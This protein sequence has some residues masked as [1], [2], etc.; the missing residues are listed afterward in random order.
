MSRDAEIAPLSDAGAGIRTERGARRPRFRGG[1]PASGLLPAAALVLCASAAGIAA[2]STPPDVSGLIP[3]IGATV[4]AVR[5]V[6]V[7]F[8][9]EVDGVDAGDLLLDGVPAGRVSGE[10]KGPYIFGFE[11]ASGRIAHVS[12]APDHGIR[13]RATPPNAFEGGGWAYRVD[14]ALPASRVL[15]GEILADNPG[16]LEDAD[17]D[18][19]DWIEVQN[20]GDD[21][22]NLDGWGLTDE[23]T[24]LD[25]WVFPP[26][27]LAPRER[28]VVFASGKDRSAVAE[29]LH[30]SFKLELDGEF[31]ALTS[32]PDAAAGTSREAVSGFW[33]YPPQRIGV[34][35]GLDASGESRYFIVPTPG[36]VNV[37]GY[38]GFV[39]DTKFGEDRGF[40]DGPFEVAITTETAGARITYTVDGSEPTEAEGIPYTGPVAISRTTTLR[41]AA[42]RAGLIPTNVDTHTYIFLDDVVSQD[43]AGFPASW[44]SVAADYRVDPEVTGSPLYGA[45]FRDDL[46]SAPTLS[47][48]MRLED[49]FG[50]TG[51]YTNPERTGTAWERPVSAELIHPDGSPGFQIDAGAQIFGNASRGPTNTGK[52][53]IRLLFKGIYGATELVHRLFETSSVESFD[54]LMLRGGYNYKWTHSSDVQRQR[55]QYARDE[56]ARQTQKDMGQPASHGIYVHLYLNGLYWGLYNVVERPD[57]SFAADHLGGDKDDYDVIKAAEPP[58]AVSGDKIFWSEMMAMANSGVSSDEAYRR[59]LEY[60]DV[61]NLIDYTI[62]NHFIGNVDAPVCICGNDRPRNFYA[63]RLRGPGGK[64]RFFAWDSEHSLSETNVDRTELG[65]TDADDTPARLYARLRQNPEFRV[66]FGDHVQK[67]FFDDG[68]LTPAA[69]VSRW[70][71]NASRIDRAV[72]GESARWGDYRRSTPYTRNAEWLAEQRRLVNTFFPVRSNVVLGQFKA[73]GLYPS[74]PAPVFGQNGGPVSPGF[75]L[76]MTAA[77]GAIYCTTDGSDPRLEGGGVSPTA[78]GPFEGAGEVLLQARVVTV[79]ARALVGSAWSAMKEAT[80][81]VDLPVTLRIVE[82]LYHPLGPPPASPYDDNDFEFIE[83]LNIG[84]EPQDLTGIRISGGVGFDFTGG[85]VGSI[86]PGERVVVVNDLVAFA[87]RYDAAAIRIAGEYDGDLG[88]SGEQIALMDPLGRA[89]LDFKYYDSWYPETDGGGRSLQIRDPLAAAENW[90]DFSIWRAS[91]APLGSPG[92]ED[93]E[94]SGGGQLPGDINGDGRTDLADA[95]GLLCSLFVEL[96]ER[97]PCEGQGM[98]DGGN[99]A[100]F[101]LSGDAGVDITDPVHLLHYLFLGGPSPALGSECVRVAGCAEACSP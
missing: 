21:W 27:L 71:G 18:S 82:V 64:Y 16:G 78:I 1:L 85:S 57:E 77:Q 96:P 5:W 19:P 99:L 4:R 90:W 67:H 22:V 30:A 73:D 79:K 74:V 60:L 28:A 100:V 66:R 38:V 45:T 84:A 42:F 34:S 11:G 56:F 15:I 3:E 89:I 80:F 13:D 55:A 6:S 49:L 87:T 83:I 14:A 69:N 39:A 24:V 26:L 94:P 95:V 46:L 65:V 61:D 47:L 86:G 88:N 98:G 50:S 70:M 91:W 44:G 48:V 97:L 68:V 31:L 25:R 37:E 58:Y 8:T 41:A 7:G 20:D 2:D 54:T 76:E 72:V 33:P 43:G 52:H 53:S 92:I 40:R 101:D 32:P 10:G 62:L 75:R 59:L 63:A 12:W 23:P 93:V 51:I 29:D 17:G 36:E 35:Y 81:V 9:E